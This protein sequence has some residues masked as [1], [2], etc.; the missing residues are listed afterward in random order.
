MDETP[1]PWPDGVKEIRIADLKR[2]G[3]NSKNQLFWDGGQVET[4]RRIDLT[5]FQNFVAAAVT[6]AAIL[7][8]LGAAVNALQ[9]GSEFLCARHIHWLSCP[10]K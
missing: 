9:D 10:A 4:R 5:G 1:E 7:G 3:I 2:L 6:C 8:G